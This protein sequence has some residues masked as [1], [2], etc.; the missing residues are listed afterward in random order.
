MELRHL[1]TF[2]AVAAELSF[3]RAAARLGYVQ[4]AVTSHIK[5]LEDELGARLF[6]RLGR[7][8]VLTYAGTQLLGYADKILQLSD[9][10]TIM[11]SQAGEP[12]GP[13]SVSAPEMLCAYRLPP[14]I[15]E[16]HRQHPGI[17][18]LFRS[19]P[20]GALDSS[21]RHALANGDID[22]AFVL[23]ENLTSTDSLRVEPLT[24][25]PLVVVAAPC[26]PLAQAAAIGPADLDGVP[27]L[28]TDKGCSY[29]RV[30]ERAL[31]SAGARPAIAGEFISSDT[32]KYCVGAGTLIGVLAR[33]SV[34]AELDTGRLIALPWNGPPLTLSSYLIV[35]QQRAISPAHAALRAA[36]RQFFVKSDIV[37]FH[38]DPGSVGPG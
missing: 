4:S 37:T 25:E 34:A 30:F 23:D 12:S 9:E 38:P 26:H 11:I 32:V 29:R 10:A 6:D 3:T 17:R 28:L 15:R 33:I 1:S 31:H 21:L 19:N 5:A 27:V 2:Q 7:R 16:L 35:H 22:T 36:T 13:V 18:L 24:S 8:I 14:V 20:T